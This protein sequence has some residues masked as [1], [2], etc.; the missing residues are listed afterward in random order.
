MKKKKRNA[1]QQLQNDLG[2]QDVNNCRQ[3]HQDCGRRS[4]HG[5]TRRQARLSLSADSL[6][7]HLLLLP[8]LTD[9]SC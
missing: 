8:F 4:V 6:G 2:A 9:V 7:M 3:L 1:R 5:A